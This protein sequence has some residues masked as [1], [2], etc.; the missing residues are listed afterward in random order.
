MWTPGE[1]FLAF[2][3]WQP[4]ACV[5]GGTRYVVASDMRMI[6]AVQSEA[7]GDFDTVTRRFERYLTAEPPHALNTHRESLAEW[8]GDP[9]WYCARCS[10]TGLAEVEVFERCER[11]KGEGKYEVRC[12]M[13]HW[14]DRECGL[15][16]ATGDGDRR[17]WVKVQCRHCTEGLAL[18]L[19]TAYR[20]GRIR[21]QPVDR[22]RLA[23]ILEI[24]PSCSYVCV[25]PM[26]EEA[27]TPVVHVRGLGWHAVLACM[28][29]DSD[30]DVTTTFE[31][32]LG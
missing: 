9:C 8:A 10:G 27:M 7:T 30:S 15:C 29:I 25:W 20:I 5:V 6:L 24:A 4:V 3:N 12:D 21:G 14:H 18:E 22:R 2:G 23:R 11:C 13:G 31:D 26:E 19:D 17:E 32:D 1:D 16:G 28:K